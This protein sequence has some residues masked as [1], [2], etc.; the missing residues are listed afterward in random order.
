MYEYPLISEERPL[1]TIKYMSV[2]QVLLITAIRHCTEPPCKWN[3]QNMH[4]C[5][6]YHSRVLWDIHI[7][8]L[9]SLISAWLSSLLS[10]PELPFA[11]FAGFSFSSLSWIIFSI[12]V[13]P[14]KR[15]CMFIQYFVWGKWE[16]QES[17]E[18]YYCSSKW[19]RWYFWQVEEIFWTRL[20]N[21]EWT[22]H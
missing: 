11:L 14:F 7:C 8:F 1:Y 2:C 16:D 15:I 19:Y 10:P 4:G 13:A 20:F 3:K 17:A 22:S 12:L 5:A 18:R 6:N 21:Q 9:R